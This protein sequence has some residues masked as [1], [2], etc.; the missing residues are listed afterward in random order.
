MVGGRLGVRRVYSL[1]ALYLQLIPKHTYRYPYTI[2]QLPYDYGRGMS[3][4]ITGAFLAR[5][6]VRDGILR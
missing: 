5:W 4:G 3:V 1:G 2:L 6:R